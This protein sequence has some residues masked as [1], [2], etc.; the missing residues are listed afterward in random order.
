MGIQSGVGG[1]GCGGAAQ[2]GA[3]KIFERGVIYVLDSSPGMF[4]SKETTHPF[5]FRYLGHAA[6]TCLLRISPPSIER[7]C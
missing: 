7:R 4:G 6:S 2:R 3:G 5:L 1:V